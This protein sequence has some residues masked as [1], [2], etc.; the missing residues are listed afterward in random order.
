MNVVRVMREQD[1]SLL[2]GDREEDGIVELLEFVSMARS[3]NVVP[4]LGEEA[5]EAV[6]RQVGVK[7]ETERL[8]TRLCWHS[9]QPPRRS[10]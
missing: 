1:A 10:G 8:T 2:L 5:D 7:Q 9:R 3:D 6:A 4:A